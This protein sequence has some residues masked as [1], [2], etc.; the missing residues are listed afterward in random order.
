MGKLVNELENYYT[1]KLL[2]VADGSF[3]GIY[4]FRFKGQV[5]LPSAAKLTELCEGVVSV[6]VEVFHVDS[7]RVPDTKYLVDM[8]LGVC[9]CAQG[10]TGAPCKHQFLL[11]S[12]AFSSS[13]ENYI[14]VYSAALTKQYADLAVNGSAPIE[15]YDGIRERILPS[16]HVERHGNNDVNNYLTDE[17]VDEPSS[18]SILASDADV[19]DHAPIPSSPQN[20][21]EADKALESS[22]TYLR[23]TLLLRDPSL[24]SGYIKWSRNLQNIPISRLGS[25]FHCFDRNDTYSIKTK[26]HPKQQKIPIIHPSR[27]KIQSG[28]KQKVNKGNR[29]ISEMAIPS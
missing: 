25:L 11:W 13:S 21:E 17:H 10:S 29:R 18:S 19:D 7:F 1:T 23:S 2:S 4:S 27:R 26:T 8:N 6:G 12:R 20:L 24:L 28:S 15:F 9:Q 14:P 3:D 5:S 16:C 22:F